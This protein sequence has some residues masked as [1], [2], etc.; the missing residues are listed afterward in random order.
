MRRY[1]MEER[2]NAL[3][4]AGEIGASKAAEQS[5]ISYATMLD[6]RKKASAAKKPPASAQKPPAVSEA[7]DALL[8]AEPPL[9][10]DLSLEF[11]IRLLQQENAQLRAQVARQAKA[12]HALA[13]TEG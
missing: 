5:G 3:K 1:S 8:G 11:Q 9:P 13:P 6:W 4:L 7:P 10:G 2:E 12:L